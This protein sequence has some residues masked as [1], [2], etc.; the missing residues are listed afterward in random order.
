MTKEEELISQITELLE[1]ESDLNSERASIKKL[2]KEYK[3]S[4]RQLNRIISM[5]DRQQTEIMQKND[6]LKDLSSKLS[7]YLS[8]Q[9]YDSIFSGKQDVSIKSKR[10]KLTVFFSD[11]VNFTGTTENLEPE[12]LSMVLNK[13]LD[14]MS[15]IALKYGATIDKFIGDAILIFFGD[16]ESLGE[17]EDAYQCVSMAIEMRERMHKIASTWRD[18][19]IQEPF[20]IRIGITTGYVTVGNFGSEHRM[21]YTVIGGQVNLASRLESNANVNDI[22]IALETYSL[23]ND[24]ILCEKKDTIFVKGIPYPV[25]TYQVINHFEKLRNK[26]EINVSGEEFSLYIDKDKMIES[27]EIR[28]LTVEKLQ[29]IINELEDI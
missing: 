18:F 26:Q 10:K 5:S 13:Y 23:V 16:P 15:T 19:G 27:K 17:K 28:D 11:I 8:P 21:D 2:L 12:Q 1:K 4:L 14:E 22:L 29:K 3:K 24:R 6:T 9:I 25:P 7:K 20:K